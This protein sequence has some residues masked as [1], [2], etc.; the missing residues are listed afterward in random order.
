MFSRIHIFSVPEKQIP[1]QENKVSATK[2]SIAYTICEL[3]K[4]LNNKYNVL[5]F[6]VL[7]IVVGYDLKIIVIQ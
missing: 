6:K 3:S 1:Q 4:L 2:G 5:Y 7:Y